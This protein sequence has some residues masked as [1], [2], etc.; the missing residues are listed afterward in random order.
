MIPSFQHAPCDVMKIPENK[1]LPV[2]TFPEVMFH[3]IKQEE[4]LYS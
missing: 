1:I 4:F 2:V 3:I